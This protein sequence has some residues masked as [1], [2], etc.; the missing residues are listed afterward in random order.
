MTIFFRTPAQAKLSQ[1]TPVREILMSFDPIGS[2]LM[3]SGVL[4]LFLA[5]GWGGVARP[6]NSATEI[7]LLVGCVLLVTLFVINEW[8]QGDRA[9][10]VFR[11]LRNRSIGACSGFIFL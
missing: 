5:V 6:W 1:G 4:C 8:Y 11:I 3:F 2:V 10:I 9:L 7:G